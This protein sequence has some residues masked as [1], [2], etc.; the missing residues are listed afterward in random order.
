MLSYLFIGAKDVEAAAR[1]YDAILSPLGYEK[2]QSEGQYCFSLPETADKSN[3]P[4]SD[5]YRQAFQRP[6]R[7]GG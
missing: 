1:F 2:D 5:S 4:G 6:T 7:Y 3:G